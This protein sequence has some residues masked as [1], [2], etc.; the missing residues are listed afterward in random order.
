MISLEIANIDLFAVREPA[1]KRS[2]SILRVGTKTGLTGYGECAPPSTGDLEKLRANWI[3]RPATTYA[4]LK[5]NSSLDA[6]MD[7]ALLDVVGK[8]TKAPVYRLLGGPTRNK[9]RVLASVEPNGL[10]PA[11][12]AG[13][14]A[15]AVRIPTPSARN[16][17]KAYQLAVKELADRIRQRGGDFVLEGGG[18]LTP[19]DAASTAATLETLHPLWFDEPCFISNQRTISKISDE[20][21]TPLGFGRGVTNAGVFQQLL[22]DG[23]VDVVRPEL[24]IH[25]ITGCR[26]IAALAEPYYVA[27]APHHDGGPVATA[28]ALHLAAS[29]PNFFIQQMPNVT[30]EEDRRMRAELA[31]IDLEHVRDGFASLPSGAGLGVTVNETALE[32]YHAA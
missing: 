18:A 12:N 24:S 28:A 10:E 14:R 23:M 7:L 2:Y 21:V 5:F 3:G 31:G 20:C 8:A 9:A 32:K 4:H 29:L 13:F 11:W 6:A 22:R 30:A 26:R 27:V 1:S 25:G 19:G 16:Q 15:F 17:G